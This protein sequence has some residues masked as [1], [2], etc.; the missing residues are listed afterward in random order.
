MRSE[1]SERSV[2]RVK[3][4]ERVRSQPSIKL[5]KDFRTSSTRSEQSERSVERVRNNIE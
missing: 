1:R 3:N 5:E 2:E 4:L